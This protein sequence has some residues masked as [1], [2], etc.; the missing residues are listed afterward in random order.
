M[1]Y[2]IVE[3]QIVEGSAA[4]GFI[5]HCNGFFNRN[6]ASNFLDTHFCNAH[7][8]AS[9]A[10]WAGLPLLTWP[11]ETFASRVA[12]SLLAAVGLPDLVADSPDAYVNLAVALALEPERM[13]NCQQRLT[14]R[15]TSPLFD[16]VAF[17]REFEQLC[18]SMARHET[19]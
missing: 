10:L 17:T 8:T 18:L 7:T 1:I 15:A 4:L 14:A 13:T 9:D 3:V 19:H 16:T 12:A 5:N 2:L 11:G 6:F